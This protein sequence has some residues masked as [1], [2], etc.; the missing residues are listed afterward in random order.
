MLYR[1][2]ANQRR[3]IQENAEVRERY[4]KWLSDPMTQAVIG[5]LTIEGQPS[6][7]MQINGDVACL[8]L[9]DGIGWANCLNRMQMLDSITKTEEP[10]STFEKQNG[11]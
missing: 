5:I 10:E 1:D 7:P 6:S 11:E 4:L 3:A 9:G 2:I 8:N